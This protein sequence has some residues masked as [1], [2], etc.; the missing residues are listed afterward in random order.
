MGIPLHFDLQI[1][2]ATRLQARHKGAIVQLGNLI[3]HLYLLQV[4]LTVGPTLDLDTARPQ[5]VDV[6]QLYPH[7]V[8][9]HR[10]H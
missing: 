8:G 7:F 10:V 3:P 5:R 4:G 2:A 6:Y 9:A 1:S